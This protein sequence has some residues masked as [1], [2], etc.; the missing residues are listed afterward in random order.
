MSTTKKY[1]LVVKCIEGEMI[2]IRK[3]LYE[4]LA[5]AKKNMIDMKKWDNKSTYSIVSYDESWG[6]L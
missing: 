2:M 4:S 5:E 6:V 3:G 1:F